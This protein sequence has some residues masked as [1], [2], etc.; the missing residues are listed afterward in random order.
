MNNA[1]VSV[2]LW[3][4]ASLTPLDVGGQTIRIA[5]YNVNYANRREDQLLDALFNELGS[6][7]A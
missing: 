5:T 7:L 6:V 2:L 4:I 1:T 3:M